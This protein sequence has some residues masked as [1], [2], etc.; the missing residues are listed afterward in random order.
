MTK[1]LTLPHN[2][3]AHENLNGPDALKRHLAL[4]G[5]LVQTKLV[6]ELILA[7]GIRVIDLV[8]KHQEG[9][10][11]QI[12]HGEEGV[13]LGLGFGEALVVLCVDQEDDPAYFGEIV[14]PQA[15][16]YHTLL[17]G[18]NKGGRRS[19]AG[20]T[21]LVTAQIEGGEP[22]VA[23][24]EFLR[25]WVCGGGEDGNAVVLEMERQYLSVSSMQI[26]STHLQHVEQRRL[27]GVIQTEEEE[28]GMLVHK[29]QRCQDIVDCMRSNQ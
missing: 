26:N 13:E 10:L 16:G 24:G 19:L 5:S 28:L 29:T 27:A 7:H 25:S 6:A 20:L 12:L 22:V 11:G 23:N 21:L 18:L 9:N 17:E 15:A 14:F 3:T 8:S 1:K 2:N 4:A